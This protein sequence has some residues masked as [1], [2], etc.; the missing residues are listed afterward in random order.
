M[1]ILNQAPRWD[2]GRCEHVTLWHGCTDADRQGL[3]ARGIDLS[4][5]RPDL[6]FGRGF[7]T[8]TLERQARH[9]AVRRYD[10]RFVTKEGN[11]PVVLRF[12]IERCELARLTWLSFVRSGYENDDFWSLVQH[13]RQ[14]RPRG[15]R[16]QAQV[17]NDHKGPIDENGYRWFEVVS[18]PVVADWEQRATLQDA[19]QFSFHT[20]R[21]V[22][23]LNAGVGSGDSRRYTW[24]QV[25][26]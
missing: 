15:K 5:S 12:E 13:C 19:D 23:L 9:W 11:A 7:Y 16:G 21:A 17:I 24:Q 25:S 4:L 26:T 8:T 20:A 3:E 1:P 18:G 2:V 6:D 10:S 22:A 14:S